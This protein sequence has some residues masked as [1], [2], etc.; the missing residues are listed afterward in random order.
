MLIGYTLQSTVSLDDILEREQ[1]FFLCHHSF[2]F[3]LSSHVCVDTTVEG[4]SVSFFKLK[5]NL[6]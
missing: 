4:L 6:Q 5:Y 2:L 3:V 1:V